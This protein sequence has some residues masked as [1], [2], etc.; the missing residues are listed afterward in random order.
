MT[1]NQFSNYMASLQIRQTEY[2]RGV[3]LT[4]GN[5]FFA[6]VA[7]IYI[8]ILLLISFLMCWVRLEIT[9]GNIEFVK[10]LQLFYGSSEV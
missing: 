8:D 6:I 2:R 3:F 4:G 1:N 7:L 10:H 5:F 9:K